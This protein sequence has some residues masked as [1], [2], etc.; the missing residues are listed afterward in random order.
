MGSMKV[1]R[2]QRPDG[3][4]QVKLIGSIDEHAD[5]ANVLG[6]AIDG[7][8]V[9]DLEGIRRINS[10][11]I[12]LW[13]PIVL[14]LSR[15][16]QLRFERVPYPVVMQANCVLNLFGGARVVSVMAPYFCATCQS[17]RMAIVEASEVDGATA[18]PSKRCPECQSTMEFDDLD[19]YF[20]FLKA[21]P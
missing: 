9:I 15:A 17:N 3:F 11:G 7:D 6:P 19:S 5:L 12:R 21:R 10:M 4:L 16:R 1:E 2:S 14:E 8:A 18:P 13:I 20:S